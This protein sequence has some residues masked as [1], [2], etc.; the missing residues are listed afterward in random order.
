MSLV[1]QLGIKITDAIEAVD[2]RQIVRNYE[3]TSIFHPLSNPL[4]QPFLDSLLTNLRCQN[5]Q[6]QKLM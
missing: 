5:L 6:R 3:N 2:Y 4:A 1:L